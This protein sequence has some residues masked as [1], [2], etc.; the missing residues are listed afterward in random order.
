[1]MLRK[2]LPLKVGDAGGKTGDSEEGKES[3]SE[4]GQDGFMVGSSIVNST[5]EDE[6]T[7]RLSP[8]PMALA[9]RKSL[10]DGIVVVD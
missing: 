9:D 10:F 6:R 7:F 1:M 8:R 3:G 5:L 4:D 2:G